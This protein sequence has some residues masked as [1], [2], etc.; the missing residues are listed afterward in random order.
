MNRVTKK[1]GIRS[2]KALTPIVAL[3]LMMTVACESQTENSETATTKN[4]KALKLGTLLPTTGDLSS[5]GQN[6]PKGVELAVDT[7]N[8]CG[9]VNGSEVIVIHEDSQT[10]PNAGISAMTKLAEI[11]QVAGVIGALLAA[12]PVLLLILQFAMKS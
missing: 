6:M 10:D 4:Q 7:I 9:G 3:L 1:N 5:I 2:L 11:D 8:A 12:F